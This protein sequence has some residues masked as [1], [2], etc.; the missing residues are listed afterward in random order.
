[1]MTEEY[2]YDDKTV[3][4]DD[5]ARRVKV[6]VGVFAGVVYG[7][8]ARITFGL[9]NGNRELFS[10][11]TWGFITFVPLGI[12]ALTVFFLPRKL[13]SSYRYAVTAPLLASFIFLGLT[14]L[15][16]FEV[17]ICILMAAPFFLLIASLGGLVMSWIIQQTGRRGYS[18]LALMLLFP[19]VL[20]PMERQMPPP[21]DSI[22]HVQTQIEINADVETVWENIIRVHEIQPEE[23]SFN[24]FHVAGV[25]KPVEATLSFEGVGGVRHASFDNGLVFI[26]TITEWQPMESLTFTIETEGGANV[27]APFNEI[28]GAMFE[29]IDGTYTI[30]PLEDG[31][32]IL[33]LWS[34]HRL[35]TRFNGYGG[36]W[37]DAVM[38]D[39]QNYILG[40]VKARSEVQ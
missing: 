15:F 39:L 32:V 37:T 28:G 40:I 13:R 33:H 18:A 25:P 20:S 11:L 23:Q 14:L 29:M 19:Y 9:D 38:H 22:R 1:M 8:F 35:T 24:L 27:P 31:R 30:E 36:L 16:A 12:G 4:L 17:F 3:E 26:E 2:K 10:T 34:N 5:Q 6:A 7:L 21:P